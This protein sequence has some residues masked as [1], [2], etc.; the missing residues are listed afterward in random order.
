MS[1]EGVF[2]LVVAGLVLIAAFVGY[3]AAGVAGLLAGIFYA[4]LLLVLLAV[5]L[6]LI[7]GWHWLWHGEQKQGFIRTRWLL[8]QVRH[9]VRSLTELRDVPPDLTPLP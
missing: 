7:A 4:V 6:D 1:R 9:P 3:V 2:K 5:V 8:W